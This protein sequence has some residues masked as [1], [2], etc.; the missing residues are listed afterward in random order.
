MPNFITS[1][2]SPG[3]PY[4]VQQRT[5]MLHGCLL[6]MCN[7]SAWQLHEM[8]CQPHACASTNH[9]PTNTDSGL[10]PHPCCHWRKS[11][12]L[13]QQTRLSSSYPRW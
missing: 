1:H 4:R 7:S 5:T 6:Y 3:K 11:S 8:H 10:K 12:Y 9:Q 13:S 2:G